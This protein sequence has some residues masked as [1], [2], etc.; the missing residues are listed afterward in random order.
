M[1]IFTNLIYTIWPEHFFPC[2]SI[3]LLFFS[4][5]MKSSWSTV[6]MFYVYSRRLLHLLLSS[7]CVGC[8]S[9][10]IWSKR[11]PNCTLC[12][13][14]WASSVTQGTKLKVWGVFYCCSSV[15]LCFLSARIPVHPLEADSYHHFQSL[16]MNIWSLLS[17]SVIKETKKLLQLVRRQS[18]S[19]VI[20]VRIFVVGL[21]L[22]PCTELLFWSGSSGVHWD[23]LLFLMF[24]HQLRYFEQSQISIFWL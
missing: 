2:T 21:W 20:V 19:C 18:S 5:L 13:G 8:I 7:D 6:L 3:F 12:V 23:F 10:C 14:S 24:T 16:F 1:L 11:L 17:P 15:R 9:S 4:N 22:W